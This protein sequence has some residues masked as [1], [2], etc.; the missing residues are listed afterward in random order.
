[1]NKDYGTPSFYDNAAN[2]YLMR[3]TRTLLEKEKKYQECLPYA[4]AAAFCRIINNHQTDVWGKEKTVYTIFNFDH[5]VD[6]KYKNAIKRNLKRLGIESIYQKLQTIII[7]QYQKSKAPLG[8]K[9][10]LKQSEAI[11]A[12]TL[13]EL[14]QK[15]YHF[16]CPHCNQ[17]YEGELT[18][19]GTKIE[20][21]YCHKKIKL[22]PIEE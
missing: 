4:C 21:S 7:E 1:M 13:L 10:V 5:Y 14:Q 22:I 8:Y 18:H 15:I 16:Y 6:D 9:K 11:I 20:C 3:D 19:I 2:M 17:H 12:E